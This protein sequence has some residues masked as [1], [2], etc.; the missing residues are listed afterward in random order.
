MSSLM[1]EQGV[2][3][4]ESLGRGKPL[5][6][7]HCWLG[8]WD[9]W[10]AT[11]EAFASESL[12]YRIYALDFWGFGESDRRLPTYEVEDY[13]AMVVQF[14]DHLGIAKA[15]VFGHS[16]GGTVAM[17]LAVEHPDRVSQVAVVG[18]PM[19]GNS[20]S[21][22]L[23]LA[24]VRWVADILWRFPPLLRF[25]LWGYSPFLARDRREVYR[26]MMRTLSQST[27]ASFCQSIASLRRK[28]LRPHLPEVQVPVLGVYGVHDWVVHPDQALVIQHLAPQ[29]RVEVFEASGHFPML[30]E[31]AR[32]HQVLRQFLTEARTSPTRAD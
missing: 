8:S 28:D 26:R 9:F 15:P 18:S 13:V 25:V 7:L 22:L 16:M 19:E 32:F 1:T 5:L 6:L 2:L 14:M 27:V 23:K 24:G 21:I 11:M 20:L 30:D 31:P 17:S 4:Y 29:A 12:G 10:R 3:H